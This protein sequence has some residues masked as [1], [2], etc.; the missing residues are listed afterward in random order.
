MSL[1][2]KVRRN[3][4]VYRL[5]RAPLY[6]TSDRQRVEQSCLMYRREAGTYVLSALGIL[7][8]LIGLTIETDAR[9]RS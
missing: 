5:L 6:R 7:N 4:F 9:E 8:G 1:Q 3:G 2:M